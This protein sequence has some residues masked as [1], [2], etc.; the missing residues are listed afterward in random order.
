MTVWA[1]SG[2]STGMVSAGMPAASCRL[3]DLETER[4]LRREIHVTERFH[5]STVW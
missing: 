2:R 4:V 1:N 5:A 3:D